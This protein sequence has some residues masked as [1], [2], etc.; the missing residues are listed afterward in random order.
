LCESLRAHAERYLDRRLADLCRRLGIDHPRLV[1]AEPGRRW[2]SCGKD[3]VVRIHWRIIQAPPALIDYVLVHELVHLS[4]R[5][6][7]RA[8]WAAVGRVIPDYE[9]RRA[10]LKEIGSGLLW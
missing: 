3:G 4:H 8:F 6:H 10:R 9:A 2:G 5:H 7:G 1:L